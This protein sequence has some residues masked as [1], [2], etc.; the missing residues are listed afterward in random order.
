[1]YDKSICICRCEKW[2]FVKK[3]EKCRLKTPWNK[4]FYCNLRAIYCK[5]MYIH[6]VN[7]SYLFKQQAFACSYTV[8]VLGNKRIIL[9]L[10][11]QMGIIFQ[12]TQF[13][14]MFWY[15]IN[16]DEN[17]EAVSPRRCQG[18]GCS[19]GLDLDGEKGWDYTCIDSQ[20]NRLIILC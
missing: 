11:N 20:S 1:M 10:Q 12:I 18:R 13:I 15:R 4:R 7:V 17:L 2:L 3:L 5:C 14:K 19:R 6:V 9:S 8:K 16:K